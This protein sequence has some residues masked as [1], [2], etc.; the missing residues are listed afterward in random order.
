MVPAVVDITFS[1][2]DRYITFIHFS[3]GENNKSDIWV[4]DQHSGKT[5]KVSVGLNGQSGNGS[6]GFIS[7]ISADGRY[8]A[9]SS[10]SSNLVPK[11]TNNA[12]DFFVR[13]RLTR[14]TERVSISSN[15]IQG[16]EDSSRRSYVRL[17]VDGRYVFFSSRSSN[18]VSGD[19][20][21][22]NDIFVHDRL[23]H[24]TERVTVSSKNAQQNTN[25]SDPLQFSVS[26]D[27]RYVAFDSSARNLAA[28]DFDN[29]SDVF[30]RDRILNTKRF[31]DLKIVAIKKLTFVKGNNIA[32]FDYTVT[33]NG[34]HTANNVSLLHLISGGSLTSF[35]PSQGKCNV[36]PT[37]AV[38]HLG[39][40]ATGKKLALQVAVKLSK[41]PKV[42]QH[43]SVTAEATDKRPTNNQV[44]LISSCNQFICYPLGF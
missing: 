39:K 2:D 36:S 11:D 37:E 22:D 15:G 32:T 20:N 38:C 31:A 42:T 18:L 40:L 7:S 4:Y 6:V 5:E 17:S 35:K 16:N 10:T 21:N 30:V 28:G 43:V 3:G 25:N 44:S 14:K 13:D 33:N 41:D 27:G 24:K 12:L 1:S 34:P 29:D 26:A 8:V 19:T 9:F 23:T